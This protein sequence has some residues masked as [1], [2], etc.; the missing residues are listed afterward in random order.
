[1]GKGEGKT[2]TEVLRVGVPI[3]VQTLRTLL[4]AL[5]DDEKLTDETILSHYNG[6]LIVSTPAPTLEV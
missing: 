4:D 3:R 2:K 5:A 1:M 6:S